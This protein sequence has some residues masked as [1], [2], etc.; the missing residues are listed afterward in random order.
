MSSIPRLWFVA[1][2]LTS[3]PSAIPRAAALR[4]GL[5]FC[6]L[7]CSTFVPSLVCWINRFFF[8]LLF[9]S[10]VENIAISYK[11]FNYECRFK[12]HVQDWAIPM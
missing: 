7:P 5:T 3:L 9:S 6:S 1:P 8:W 11:I 12:Q 2:Q 10:R 4:S